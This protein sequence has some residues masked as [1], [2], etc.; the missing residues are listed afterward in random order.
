MKRILVSSC[1]LGFKVRYNGSDAEVQDQ[2]WKR[3]QKE[4]R[5][6]SLCPE[7]AA[8]F[9]VPRPP[10]EIVGGEGEN[11][12]AG[13]AQI[14]EDV[15]SDVTE[16]FILGAKKTLEFAQ[17][18]GLELAILTDGSPSCGS[19]YIY[20]GTFT[21]NRKK[22]KGVVTSLLEQHGI[23]IFADHQLLEADAYVKSIEAQS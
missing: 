1:L 15:G 9:S 7:L 12:L 13:R 21:G 4:G 20:D 22:G 11:V 23:R 17:R 2:I 14:L 10:A 16:L 18:Q 6:V 5:L 3:W 19:S 8:G